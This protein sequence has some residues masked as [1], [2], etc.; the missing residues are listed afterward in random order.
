M[1]DSNKTKRIMKIRYTIISIMLAL[2]A[3]SCSS[4][5]EV[6][7]KGKATIPS[8]LSDPNGLNAA[9][10]GAYNET[11]DYYDN[12]FGKYA[13][14]AGNMIQMNTTM[15]EMLDIYNY[16]SDA[17]NETSSSSYIWRRIYKAMANVNNIIEYGDKVRSAYPAQRNKINRIMGEAFFLRALSH[18]DL[19]RTFAQPYNY[20]ENATH[21]GV[22]LLKKTPGPDD[23]PS[24]VSVAEVYKFISEDLDSAEARLK[25]G[26]QRGDRYV[27]LQAVYAMK[28]RVALYMENWNSAIDNA[29]KALTAN[30]NPSG[31]VTDHLASADEYI[32]QF[33]NLSYTGEIILRLSGTDKKGK[34]KSFYE[35]TGVPADT[36]YS[37]Y[38]SNDIRLALLYNNGKKQC[39]KYSATTSPDNQTDRDDPIILRLSEVYLNAAEASAM[40]NDYRSARQFILPIV[41]R[42]IG[43]TEGQNLI[44]ECPDAKLLDLI[45]KERTKE[46]CFE[47]HN[48]FDITRWKQDLVRQSATTSTVKRL[49]YPNDR[50]VQPIPL[51]ELNANKNMQ[52]NSGVND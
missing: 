6:E 44:D 12:E 25:S 52:P 7:E 22:P 3:S 49:T 19:C 11:Y 33:D 43:V 35:S 1:S 40:N 26:T 42:A 23:N 51:A 24:R 46:L 37:L 50:F 15:S 9:L 20:S 28:S 5:L 17:S 38:E 14:A 13:D 16:N 45:K 32:K 2:T 27:S 30:S 29:R 48:F 47:N 10:A 34:L 41:Q 8:F 36:L 39:R 4:F 18:Y 21:L 31:V